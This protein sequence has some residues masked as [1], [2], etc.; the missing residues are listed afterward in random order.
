MAAE[1]VSVSFHFRN[2][3][4]NFLLTRP[5]RPV[6]VD[7]KGEFDEQALRDACERAIQQHL[8]EGVEIRKI[9]PKP[10]SHD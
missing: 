8:H 3:D 7:C 2:G 6:K 4:Y 5:R 1:S 9:V 10:P